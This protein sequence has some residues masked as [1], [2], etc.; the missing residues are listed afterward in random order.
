MGVGNEALVESNL[1]LQQA[2]EDESSN[3]YF[4]IVEVG[5]KLACGVD[6]CLF[7]ADNARALQRHRN[8]T[9]HGHQR[10]GRP[11]VENSLRSRPSVQERVGRPLVTPEN[12]PLYL[13]D[14]S[15]HIHQ[16]TMFT[17]DPFERKF[18]DAG[19]LG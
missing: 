2:L 11:R 18:K 10:P 17:K 4:E 19:M 5:K 1:M 14:E 16:F 12:H 9:G 8:A 13:A 7:Q 6:D 3:Y 15:G